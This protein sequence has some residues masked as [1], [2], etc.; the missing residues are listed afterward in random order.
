MVIMSGLMPKVSQPNMFPVRANPQMTS[1]AMN[2]MSCFA[3]TACI[4]S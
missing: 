1:S 4:L 2:K 3:K